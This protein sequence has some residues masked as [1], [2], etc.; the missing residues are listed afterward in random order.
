VTPLT[1][2][3]FK[4]SEPIVAMLLAQRADPNVLDRTG[5]SAIAYAAARGFPAIVRRL[6]D[7]GVAADARTGND[8]T[9]LMWAAGHEEGVDA[10]AAAI[11]QLLLERGAPLDAADNRGRT[12]LMIAAERGDA[13]MVGLLIERG[14]DAGRRD[15]DGKSARD[16]AA[17]A[18]V[19]TRL[20]AGR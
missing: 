6:L 11:V 17:T 9:A 4:G 13:A 12:A 3:A 5:K 8:L 10:A 19:S 14:A 16:L 1:A 15:N 2:A 7:A 18:A 20:P